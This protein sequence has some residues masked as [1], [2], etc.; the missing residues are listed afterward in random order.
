MYHDL[1]VWAYILITLLL[2][3]I[4]IAGV[5]IYLHRNQT[6]RA[7]ELHPL[8]S[9]LFRFWLWLT[10]GMRTRDWVAVHRKHHAMVETG[11]DPHSPQVYGIKKVL[12][13]GVDLYRKEIVN[14]ETL[15][16]YGHGTPDDWLERNLYSRF[17]SLGITLLFVIYFLLFG[18]IGITIWAVQMLWIPFLA[19]GV[20]NGVGHWWG[21]RNFESQDTSTN[22]VP[23]GLL[24]G[25]EELHNNHHAFPTS[26]RFSSKWFELDLGWQY[27]RTMQSLGL[28]R[29]RKLAP[30]LIIDFDKR[31]ADLDTVRAIVTNR[32]HVMTD[33]ARVVVKRVY[34]EEKI[35]ATAAKRKL[36]ASN[37]RFLIKHQALLDAG[38]EQRLKELFSHSDSLQ[39]VYEFGQRLQRMWQEKSASYEHLL[40]SLQ[41]WCNQAEATGIKA[42]QEFATKIRGYTLQPA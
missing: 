16:N 29:V 9:H 39:T 13:D 33:Y 8:V 40:E 23:F 30:K 38:A 35:K 41:E 14:P 11:D 24:I 17:N 32:L 34:K 36:L 20:I 5:T 4:T 15:K 26:A 10:T 21:Y 42:L 37:K 28:A 18:F 7:V 3:H 19:A 12:F 6:H 1:P 31:L 2:T 22:I 27:I 25:G